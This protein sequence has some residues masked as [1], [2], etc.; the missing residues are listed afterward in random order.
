MQARLANGFLRGH[1]LNKCADALNI[2]RETARTHLKAVLEKSG[3]RRQA[4]LIRRAAAGVAGHLRTQS[5]GDAAHDA[6]M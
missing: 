6:V 2:S 1:T 4:D 3:A 5:R